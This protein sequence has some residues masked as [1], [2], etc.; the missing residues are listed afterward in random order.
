MP[1]VPG[2]PDPAA[3]LAQLQANADAL[4]QLGPTIVGLN[5]ALR[6]LTGVIETARTT[7]DSA[8]RV[9]AQLERVVSE[10][11]E[12]A[13]ALRPGLE[14]AARVLDDPVMDTLPDT[15]RR[16]QEALLPMA[17]GLHR[18]QSRLGQLTA[19]ATSSV[20]RLAAGRPVRGAGD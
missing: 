17:D 20:S 9:T 12:P 7:V 1:R 5:E 4:A 18:V 6:G 10:L 3:V 2:L 15:V 16:L 19:T 14:R 11:E 8:Q 13:R